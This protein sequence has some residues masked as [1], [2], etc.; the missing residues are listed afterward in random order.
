[1]NEW[2]EALVIHTL[3]TYSTLFTPRI[4]EKLLQ[5]NKY[6]RAFNHQMRDRSPHKE[7][8]HPPISNFKELL[9]V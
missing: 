7:L 4:L 9:V 1:M 3:H 6:L 2:Y 8:R 5:L